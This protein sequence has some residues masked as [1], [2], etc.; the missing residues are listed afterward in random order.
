[1]VN[2]HHVTVDTLVAKILAEGKIKGELA[3][4]N[5]ESST[6][7]ISTAITLFS[8]PV[9]LNMFDYL[10]L[11]TRATETADLLLKGLLPHS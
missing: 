9:A 2:K 5:I 1:V 7:A 3:F 6:R 10:S 8:F 4:E 11:K